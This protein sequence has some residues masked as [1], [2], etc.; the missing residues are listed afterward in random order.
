[1]GHAKGVLIANIA[2]MAWRTLVPLVSWQV[3]HDSEPRK[4]NVNQSSFLFYI[5]A[6]PLGLL[7]PTPRWTLRPSS[8]LGWTWTRKNLVCYSEAASK[9]GAY[10]ASCYH[11]DGEGD[12]SYGGDEL[13]WEWCENM[14]MR[15]QD[16]FE[17]IWIRGK[18]GW[19][20]CDNPWDLDIGVGNTGSTIDIVDQAKERNHQKRKPLPKMRKNCSMDWE[21]ACSC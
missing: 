1:M 6:G 20:G 12:S 18:R 10:Q 16:A 2:W 3:I 9:Y 11:G 8:C 19:M 15:V 7:E 4:V 13:P 14:Q 5:Q 17:F 21:G